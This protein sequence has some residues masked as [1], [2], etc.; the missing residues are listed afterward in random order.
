MTPLELSI[1]L[2]YH[3]MGEDM[4]WCVDENGAP[5]RGETMDKLMADGLLVMQAR[6][7]PIA[8]MQYQPTPKLHAF[9]AMLCAT[10]LPV[11][12]WA[13]PRNGTVLEG[14]GVNR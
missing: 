6:Q 14:P 7:T 12:T 11:H 1:C 2:H 8:L 3:S 10:P 4:R 5:I 9:V 13:D